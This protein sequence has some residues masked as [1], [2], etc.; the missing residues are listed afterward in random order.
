MVDF[1]YFT[2]LR[3]LRIPRLTYSKSV[4][5]LQIAILWFFDSILL[6]GMTINA[7]WSVGLS[8]RSAGKR[9]SSRA[10]AHVNLSGEQPHM[11]LQRPNLPTSLISLHRLRSA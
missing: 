10:S 1:I 5:V 9:C 3:Q 4:V 2:A 6:G 7:P 8:T 11:N